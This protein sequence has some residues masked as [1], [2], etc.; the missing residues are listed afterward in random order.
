MI[1]QLLYSAAY[2]FHYDTGDG[3]PLA[4]GYLTNGESLFRILVYKVN[5]PES[6]QP[7]FFSVN[8]SEM[9]LS[10]L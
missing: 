5:Q 10:D 1:K 7:N 6:L 3:K 4:N 2:C 8:R 9:H